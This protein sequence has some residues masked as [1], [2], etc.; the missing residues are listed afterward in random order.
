MVRDIREEGVHTAKPDEAWQE[1]VFLAW[2][3]PIR[4]VGG[5]HRIGIEV[6]RGLSNMWCGVFRTGGA[7]FRLN[8]DLVP[9]EHHPRGE[10]FICGPQRLF[11][12]DRSV[13]W[14][15]DTPDCMVELEVEDHATG[16]LWT[17]AGLTPSVLSVA[18][19]GHYHHHCAV[20]GR[21]RLGSE[22]FEVA[23]DGWR[24][25]SWG[26]RY[27]DAI[28]HHRNVSGFFAKGMS[29]DFGSLLD[30]K[31]TL[32]PFGTIVRDGIEQRLTD[33]TLT[34]AIDQD[35]LTARSADVVG[36]LPSGEPFSSHIDVAD[37]VVVQTREYVGIETVGTMIL[38][39]GESGF[40][41][42]AVSNN[43]RAG[44][45]TPPLALNAL[46]KNGFFPKGAKS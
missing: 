39:S 37:G 31:G 22:S 29:A 41:Y 34:V 10:G 4:S 43:P 19:L 11:H 32:S 38:S 6:N 7:R 36:R 9:L 20:R 30:A 16:D 42:M 40:G 33:F 44:R 23:G 13:R 21:V 46:G 15:L 27:W 28:L 5:I 12:D 17:G 14:A 35:G 18:T 8:Q 1:S 25:H 26:P 3:D 2:R 45:A 24:D